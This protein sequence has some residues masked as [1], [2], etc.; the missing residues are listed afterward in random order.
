MNAASANSDW[1]NLSGRVCVVTGAAGGIGTTLSTGFAKAGA[2]VA[3]LD[4]DL[5]GCEAVAGRIRDGGGDA[6]AIACDISSHDSVSS[7]ANEC[8]RLLGP[9]D[10]L[11][12]NAAALHSGPLIETPVSKWSELLSI[13]LTGYFLCSQAFGKSMAERRK[14]SIVHV[15]SIAGYYPQAYSGAYSVSKAGVL[16][17]SQ[18]LAVEMGEYNVRSNVVS[19]AMVRTPLSE[20]FYSDPDM[21]RRREQIVPSRR[22]GTPTDILEV[23]LF[24]AS[25]RASYVNGQELL[26]DGGV[27]RALLGLIPRPGYEKKSA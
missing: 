20:P 7:A 27:S 23:A 4:R 21:L 22:I 24:L 13:N 10:V 11:V 17:L 12:N 6:A 2:K 18:I 25:D 16:M 8:A 14:G 26:V 5:K 15:A 1:L 19:P 9:C 3:L